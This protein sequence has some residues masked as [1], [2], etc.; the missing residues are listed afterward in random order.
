MS[1]SGHPANSALYFPL[2]LLALQYE[3]SCCASAAWN[4]VVM[5]RLQPER[6]QAMTTALDRPQLQL[7]SHFYTVT[8]PHAVH[9]RRIAAKSLHTV[10]ENL[11]DEVITMII[12]LLPARHVKRF[13]LT[14][15]LFAAWAELLDVVNADTVG[16]CS[17]PQ[18]LVHGSKLSDLFQRRTIR[19][20]VLAQS[21]QCQT[22]R[23]R[24]LSM[25]NTACRLLRH[26]PALQ[27]LQLLALEY[28]PANSHPAGLVLGV[29]TVLNAGV[30]PQLRSLTLAGIVP[31]RNVPQLLDG[32]AKCPR[33]HYLDLKDLETDAE[34]D[35]SHAAP[36]AAPHEHEPF[37]QPLLQR[38]LKLLDLSLHGLVP[39]LPGKIRSGLL[40]SLHNYRAMQVLDV[41]GALRRPTRFCAAVVK[42]PELR[43]LYMASTA[44]FTLPDETLATFWTGLAA[45][46]GERIDRMGD[47]HGPRGLQL[48]DVTGYNSCK[49]APF[50]ERRQR[51]MLQA[52]AGMLSN[53]NRILLHCPIPVP[54]SH[55]RRPCCAQTLAPLCNLEIL[56]PGPTGRLAPR[57]AGATTA[58]FEELGPGALSSKCSGRRARAS[59]AFATRVSLC[60]F[61]AFAASNLPDRSRV[62]WVRQQIFGFQFV[63]N[64]S[65]ERLRICAGVEF[66]WLLFASTW[67]CGLSAVPKPEFDDELDSESE[68]G[69]EPSA[70]PG[71]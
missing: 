52:S 32:A 28:L 46:G 7:A 58:D 36:H 30:L 21:R 15:R 33:L 54:L 63:P 3:L 65:L 56:A 31:S 55:T 68:Q 34:T 43:E 2:R 11:P 12:A 22:N 19:S 47:Y 10:M 29:I 24:G 50:F 37:A 48:L 64:R 14:C 16:D 70:A 26:R 60:R 13:A 66:E 57:P 44:L 35:S 67:F 4:G 69:E 25:D 6:P 20:L 8:F 40:D 41:S 51:Q 61:I 53:P 1:S 62:R 45:L 71:W 49:S 23:H 38:S 39:K 42:L 5:A 18:L 17:G 27:H 59:L 9:L